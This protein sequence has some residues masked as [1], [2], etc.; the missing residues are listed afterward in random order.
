[1]KQG[2]SRSIDSLIHLGYAAVLYGCLII[3]LGVEEYA[4]WGHFMLFVAPAIITTAFLYLR[5]SVGRGTVGKLPHSARLGPLSRW[6][7]AALIVYV[8]IALLNQFPILNWSNLT[9]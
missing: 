4:S 3:F 7:W 6:M 8:L 9:F 5:G 1:M 2:R